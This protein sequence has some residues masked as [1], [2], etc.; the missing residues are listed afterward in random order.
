M[1]V[2]PKVEHRTLTSAVHDAR[3]GS[4]RGF[5]Q[6]HECAG[7]AERSSPWARGGD[8]REITPF[9]VPLRRFVREPLVVGGVS[10]QKQKT[11][12]VLVQALM[13]AEVA[14]ATARRIPSFQSPDQVVE[15]PLVTPV[16]WDS[17]EFVHDDELRVVKDHTRLG[18]SAK[19]A[20]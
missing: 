14:I 5:E 13:H 16:D 9:D 15:R 11:G 17:S 8:Q 1:F 10:I 20:R 19:Q 3:R 6:V 12:N 4:F 2:H 18:P 7:T